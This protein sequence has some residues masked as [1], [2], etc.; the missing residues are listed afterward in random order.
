[1]IEIEFSKSC[2]VLK[3]TPSGDLSADDFDRLTEVFDQY[4]NEQDKIPN[5]VINIS[6]FPHWDGFLAARKHF[7]FVH[8]HHKAIEKV[9]IVSDNFALTTLPFLVDHFVHAK[10]RQFKYVDLKDAIKWAESEKDHPGSFLVLED[11]PDHVIGLK[12]A[13]DHHVTG[14]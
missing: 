3:I 11:L 12:A 2:K 8:D 14:L 1:M 9:A 7:K 10:V 4:V 5:L 13:G 6:N